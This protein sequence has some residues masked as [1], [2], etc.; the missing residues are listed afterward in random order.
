MVSARV[1]RLGLDWARE[2]GPELRLYHGTSPHSS[3]RE[4]VRG[5][6]LVEG[7]ASFEGAE[8]EVDNNAGAW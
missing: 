7:R 8:G 3:E 1:V 4:E 6:P 5:P 2:A